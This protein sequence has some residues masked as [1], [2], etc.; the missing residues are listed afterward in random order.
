V[1]EKSD[2]D[3]M[4][5][6]IWRNY[7]T[8]GVSEDE[9]RK[10]RLFRWLPSNPNHARCTNCYA[11]FE[12]VGGSVVKTLYNKRPSPHNP[13]ICNVCET[14][15]L[16]YQGGAEIELSM[17]F[18]DVRGST[19]MAESMSPSQFQQRINRYYKAATSI[20]IDEFAYIDKIVGD[21]VIAFFV[22]GLVGSDH[23]RIAIESAEKL[24]RATGH[25][26]PD[27]PWI[28][29]GAGV[30]TGI[31]YFGTV[32]SSEGMVDITALGDSVNTAARLASTA[33]TGE[34]VVSDAAYDA[35]GQTRD[36]LERRQLDLKGKSEATPVRIIHVGAK[37]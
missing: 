19:Q 22:P 30:H 21:E 25:A 12:G 2:H 11:P 17:L 18:A 36:D 32:G 13:R 37:K 27:G 20:L 24:L 9:T 4:I 7:L 28:P 35:A 15:A 29:V 33:G 14:F 26:D 31:A 16:E 5:E 23:A 6:E 1:S 34:I 8:K 3:A 10:R